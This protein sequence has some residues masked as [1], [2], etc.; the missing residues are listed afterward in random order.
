MI[1]LLIIRNNAT[2]LAIIIIL[3]CITVCHAV[4]FTFFLGEPGSTTS[5]GPEIIAAMATP[6]FLKCF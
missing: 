3:F 1:F 6:L 2:V 5:N 4:H